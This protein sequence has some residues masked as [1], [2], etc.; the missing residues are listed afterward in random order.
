[1]N[2]TSVASVASVLDRYLTPIPIWNLITSIYT[3]PIASVIGFVLNV[4]CLIVLFHRKL[5]GDTYKYL[6]LK[7]LIHLIFLFIMAISPIIRCSSCPISLTLFAKIIQYYLSL[8]VLNLMSTYAFLV[9]IALTYDRLM[10]LK[11][12]KSK[13]LIKLRFWP[14]TISFTVV[15][16]IL[17]VPYMLAFK[18]QQVPA[19]TQIWQYMR[20]DLGLSTFYRI[21]VIVFNMIQSLFALVV[22][23]V[24]NLLVKLE[25]SKYIK[26]KKNLTVSNPTPLRIVNS[27]NNQNMMNKNGFEFA[28]TKYNQSN[29]ASSVF[30]STSFK[31][32]K[33]KRT[34]AKCE[35]SK[36]NKNESAE[37]NFTW[38]IIVAS[39]LFSATRLIQF[40]NVTVDMIFREMGIN[41]M[42]P[43]YLAFTSFFSA[44]VYYGS[45]LFTYIF[46]NK[47]FKSCFRKIFHI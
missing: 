43:S 9:E 26:R 19:D 41:S 30:Q 1:M 21:Y 34:N 27:Q 17:N 23:I 31:E 38:M 24:L 46:F 25:F 16:L 6:I 8:I 3:M 4:S 29:E 36:R 47:V 32:N 22:L 5:N 11:Q 39:L 14:T 2:N 45:N 37:L 15:G 18:Y 44:I 20:T 33:N 10:M 35:K 28:T 12:Q 7:T 40:I 42:L 13:Y